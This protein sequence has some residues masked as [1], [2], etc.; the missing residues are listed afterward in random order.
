[1]ELT[2]DTLAGRLSDAPAA[3]TTVAA[4]AENTKETRGQA[5]KKRQLTVE[6]YEKKTPV[7]S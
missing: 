2:S 3:P 5:T 7:V 6:E 4:A 1:M